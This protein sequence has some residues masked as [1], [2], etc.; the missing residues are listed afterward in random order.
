VQRTLLALLIGAVALGRLTS[1]HHFVA[2]HYVEDQMVSI[3][4]TSCSSSTAVTLV[5]S[6]NAKDDT[7]VLR[8]VSA[9]WAS[10]PRA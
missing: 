5:D 6:R 2:V 4:A 3:E 1:A 8:Q 7:G 9:E 10:A